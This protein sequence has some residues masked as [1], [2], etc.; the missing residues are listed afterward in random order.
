MGSIRF[1]YRE[2]KIAEISSSVDFLPTLLQDYGNGLHFTWRTSGTRIPFFSDQF[3]VM[4]ERL[5]ASYIESDTGYDQAR[6]KKEITSLLT[7][8][9]IF[10]GALLHLIFLIHD[11]AGSS[12]SARLFM[13]VEYLDEEKFI[14]NT[15]GLILG[16]LSEPSVHNDWLITRI[17]DFHPMHSVWQQD[18]KEM[19]LDAG[20]LTSNRGKIIECHD[21][22][23]FIVQG[24][25]LYT[26]AAE[27]G[28]TPRAIRRVILR[29]APSLGLE[30][31]E[32]GE[33]EPRHL[34]VADEIFI[35]N[36]QTGI[37]WV[38]GHG[39]KRFF[40]KYSEELLSVIN[41]DWAEAD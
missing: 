34:D 7:R 28:I 2:G 25:R 17:G 26:P 19:N 4:V 29:L 30:T 11:K 14:L 40:R 33:L 21:A 9:R 5:R 12:G 13:T 37:R 23:I 24:K 3:S 1:W 22:V 41:R 18:Q 27:L 35:A 10:K 38:A 16:K 6:L 20:Y 32:T 36:D 15:R 39:Q 31:I 8:N